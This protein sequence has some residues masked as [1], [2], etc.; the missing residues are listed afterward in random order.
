MKISSG[1]DFIEVEGDASFV[2]YAATQF[3]Y[4]RV[5]AANSLAARLEAEGRRLIAAAECHRRAAS[6][7]AHRITRL[8]WKRTTK[9]MERVADLPPDQP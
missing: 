3:A 4:L 2:R 1:R 7:E 5:D 9:S 6:S 8:A